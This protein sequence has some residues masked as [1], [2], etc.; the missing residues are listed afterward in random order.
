MPKDICRQMSKRRDTPLTSGPGF[1]ERT[2][3]IVI[4]QFNILSSDVCLR[5]NKGI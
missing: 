5:E 2:G 4:A 3:E 1:G